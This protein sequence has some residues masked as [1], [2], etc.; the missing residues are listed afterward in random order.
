MSNWA[1]S[2]TRLFKRLPGGLP[3][4]QG[5]QAGSTL[6]SRL[7]GPLRGSFQDHRSALLSCGICRVGSSQCPPCPT[8]AG[9]ALVSG[10]RRLG[11]PHSLG[12]RTGSSTVSMVEPVL[13]PSWVS[14]CGSYF[15]FD[16]VH[17]RVPVR[18]SRPGRPPRKE[19]LVARGSFRHSL[20]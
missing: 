15:D 5:V 13:A 1:C 12:S 8:L 16:A 10:R 14:S 19:V 11:R 4:R 9:L 18:G 20:S 2:S 7:S 6:V 3:G 17:R